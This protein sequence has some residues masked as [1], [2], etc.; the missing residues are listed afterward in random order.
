MNTSSSKTICLLAVLALTHSSLAFQLHRPSSLTSPPLH[1]QPPSLL[2][3]AQDPNQEKDIIIEETIIQSNEYESS[4]DWDA[5]WKKVVENKD[6]PAKRPNP[7]SDRSIL[8]IEATVAKNKVKRAVAKNVF[9]AKEEMRRSVSGF[10]WRSLQG[11]WKFWIGIIV[12]ISFGLSILSVSGTTQAN[13][14]FYI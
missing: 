12:V 13:E 11:D 9:E 4:V 7:V 5:E 1:K 8:E 10:S 2:L 6:Q 14:S 3:H